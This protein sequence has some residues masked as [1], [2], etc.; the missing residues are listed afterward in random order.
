MDWGQKR[1]E[2]KRYPAKIA[3]KSRLTRKGKMRNPKTGAPRG[4][5]ATKTEGLT[6]VWGKEKKES[7]GDNRKNPAYR[8]T[9]AVMGSAEDRKKTRLFENIPKGNVVKAKSRKGKNCGLEK[10]R[11]NTGTGGLI[12]LSLFPAGRGFQSGW[13]LEKQQGR[14][15]MNKSS[16][17]YLNT[18][19]L[20]PRGGKKASSP[21]GRGQGKRMSPHNRKSWGGNLKK[22]NDKQQERML[23]RKKCHRLRGKRTI[24]F[25]K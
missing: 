25:N 23:S 7:D 19:G 11:E 8:H 6:R 14:R 12:K 20:K 22:K 13:E 24:K 4:G 15:K 17:R 10:N 2:K 1:S 21:G 9:L 5:E 16:T 18:K 3:K